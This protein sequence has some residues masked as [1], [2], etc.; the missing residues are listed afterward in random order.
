MLTIMQRYVALSGHREGGAQLQVSLYIVAE[1]STASRV[2]IIS[3]VLKTSRRDD[4]LI[5]DWQNWLW[6]LPTSTS[7]PPMSLT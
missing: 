1:L 6:A 2:S 3:E 5:E 4:E 7:C